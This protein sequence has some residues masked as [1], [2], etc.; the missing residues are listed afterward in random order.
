LWLSANGKYF[1]VQQDASGNGAY[2]LCKKL[3]KNNLIQWQAYSINSHFE[4]IIQLDS[5]G[6]LKKIQ[7]FLGNYVNVIE[8][9]TCR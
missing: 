9:V 2:Q 7:E 6:K 1:L 5:N 3:G 4:G 8:S